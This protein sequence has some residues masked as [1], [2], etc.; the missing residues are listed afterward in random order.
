MLC[1]FFLQYIDRKI[2]FVFYSNILKLKSQCF[3]LFCF[4]ILN[5][6]YLYLYLYGVETAAP[7]AWG[8]CVGLS[9]RALTHFLQVLRCSPTFSKHAR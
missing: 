4:F 2:L 7:A 5:P 3:V 8:L 1:M 6:L 9:P